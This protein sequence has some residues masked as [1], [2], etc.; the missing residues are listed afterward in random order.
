MV[1]TSTCP[2]RVSSDGVVGTNGWVPK[3]EVIFYMVKLS[4]D[5]RSAVVKLESIGGGDGV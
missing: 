5:S 2:Q 4:D 1:L 3:F